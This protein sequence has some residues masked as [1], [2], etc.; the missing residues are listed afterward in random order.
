MRFLKQTKI[1]LNRVTLFDFFFQLIFLTIDLFGIR[2]F[3]VFGTEALMRV[4]KRT[5]TRVN[6]NV[7]ML[8]PYFSQKYLILS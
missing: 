4:F 5:R 8:I 1:K 2:F 6:V 3:L 7:L